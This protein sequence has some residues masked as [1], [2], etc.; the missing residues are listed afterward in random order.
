MEG[1][2]KYVAKDEEGILRDQ[3]INAPLGSDW[4]TNPKKHELGPVFLTIY[5]LRYEIARTYSFLG[6]AAF[7]K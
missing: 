7:N 3:N 1:H 2:Q 4:V 5:P 6:G